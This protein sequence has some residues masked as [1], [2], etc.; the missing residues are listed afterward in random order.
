MVI[1][2]ISL[3]GEQAISD[4]ATNIVRAR[5]SRA[6]ALASV[7]VVHAGRPQP[8]AR[9][10]GLFCTC[11][12]GS[13]ARSPRWWRRRRTCG[14]APPTPVA[15]TCWSSTRR[16]ELDGILLHGGAALAAAPA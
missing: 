16:G 2:D 1:L 11:C 14:G 9:I 13:W 7:L 8:R 3:L 6:V 15:S 4:G 5:S 12:G 10:A